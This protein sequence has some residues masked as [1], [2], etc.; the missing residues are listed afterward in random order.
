LLV[1]GLLVE[2]RDVGKL[3]SVG[4]LGLVTGVPVFTDWQPESS[5]H[6]AIRH[7]KTIW[8]FISAQATE[9]APQ[10]SAGTPRQSPVETAQVAEKY[11]WTP[12]P[13]QPQRPSV[14]R[15]QPG[16]NCAE[17]PLTHSTS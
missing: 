15:E 4:P 2:G 7:A 1:G 12:P 14:G 8:A 5:A 13:P 17:P 3:G 11:E 9:Q 10:A 16:T 6:A